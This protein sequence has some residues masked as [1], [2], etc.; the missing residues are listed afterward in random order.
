VLG[1]ALVVIVALG[2]GL[3]VLM[4]FLPDPWSDPPL[5]SDGQ[6]IESFTGQRQQ[7]EQLLAMFQSDHTL[8]TDP[9]SAK[10]L[11]RFQALMQRLGVSDVELDSGMITITMA[12]RGLVTSG[13]SKGYVYTMKPPSPLV[14]DTGKWTGSSAQGDRYRH[15]GGDWYVFFEWN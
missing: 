9:M 6:L 12:D 8:Q 7:F 11:P 4:H 14:H 15:I 10:S 2:T 5:P 13:S 1:V 3:V